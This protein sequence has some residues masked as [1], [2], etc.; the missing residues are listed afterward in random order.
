VIEVHKGVRRP[1]LGSEFL[2]R[3]HVVGPLQKCKEHL[4]RLVL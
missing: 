3:D 2:A 4:E 1:K